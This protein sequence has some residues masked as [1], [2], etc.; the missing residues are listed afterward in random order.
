MRQA[1]FVNQKGIPAVTQKALV[2]SVEN[3]AI[4]AA[5]IQ[6]EECASCSAGCGAKKSCFE[7]ANPRNL[8]VKKGEAVLIGASKKMQALQGT[9]SLLLPVAC[10]VAG[11]LLA[12]PLMA[13]LG[14]T[15]TSDAKAV[16]VL[17]FLF[18]SSL[19]VFIVT[20]RFPVPGKPEIIEVLG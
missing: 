9:V 7:V 19:A 17:L 6:K 16:F 1:A 18:L 5:R 4:L 15:V 3:D 10:A 13:L 12:A 11:Y 14:K 8:A 20:R 2:V